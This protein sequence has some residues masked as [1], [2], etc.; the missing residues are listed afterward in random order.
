M[1]KYINFLMVFLLMVST[2]SCQRKSDDRTA[3]YLHINFQEGDVPSLHPHLLVSHI[4]GRSLGKLLYE[5][6]TRIDGEGNPVLAGAERVEISSDQIRYLFSLRSNACW[7]DGSKVTAAHYVS[8]WRHALTPGTDCPRAD[9]FYLIKGGRK[10]KRGEIA[11]ESVGIQAIDATTLAVELEYPSAHF[12]TLLA[13]S[14]LAPLKNPQVE[15]KEFNGPFALKKW[16]KGVALQLEANPHFWNQDRVNLQ[17]IDIAFVHDPMSAVYMYEKEQIDWIGDPFSSLPLESALRFIEKKEIYSIPINRFCW[18]YLNTQHPVLQSKKIR[19]ALGL[20]IDR[21]QITDH[22]CIDGEPMFTPVHTGM[23]PHL[24]SAQID[25]TRAKRLFNEGLVELDL[26]PETCPAITLNYPHLPQRKQLAE[27]LQNA[28]EQA[29]GLA[30]KV[31]GIEWNTFRSN[32][33]KKSFEIS[34]GCME[35][36]LYND[37]LELLERFEGIENYNPPQWEDHAFKEKISLIRQEVDPAIR[38]QLLAEAEEILLDHMPIIPVYRN[39]L[40]YVHPPRLK[41]Y[42][43]DSGGSIDFAYAS[44]SR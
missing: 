22:I 29:F 39:L 4:R 34:G 44:F 42:V 15:P 30:I 3:D 19:Q 20:S 16:D 13:Q 5:G 23:I 2:H 25:L 43:C 40:M 33:D 14:V 38:K 27:Y 10:A 8:A 32:L 17:A 6:L 35:C 11:V 12:L 37:S 7:S 18:I 28:W 36:A 26:I 21:K 24:Q 9:V 31:Q 1:L 41:D